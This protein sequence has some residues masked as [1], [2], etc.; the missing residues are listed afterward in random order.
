MKMKITKDKIIQALSKIKPRDFGLI[1][2]LLTL[3]LLNIFSFAAKCENIRG[4]VLRLHV[5]ANSDSEVDQ[6]M[7]LAVRDAVLLAGADIFDGS[8]TAED[9]AE[10]ISPEIERLTEVAR[11]VVQ[12]YNESYQVN[13]KIEEEF[14]DT[15]SY[16][17]V[18]LPAGKYRALKIIIGE[19]V[20]ENWW[21]VMFPPLCLPA[22]TGNADD[23]LHIVF[24]EGEQNLVR[25][26]P[27]YELRFKIV[28]I[29]EK[30]ADKFFQGK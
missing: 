29:Y 22:A 10:K 12:E 24:T 2:G 4:E 15:R 18:T 13:M 7:K 6:S 9:A 3:V 8:V 21:C 28:E 27:K 14:F 25:S 5:I 23:D 11:E 17:D 20:G 30:L 16:E 1:V 19:G 26:S